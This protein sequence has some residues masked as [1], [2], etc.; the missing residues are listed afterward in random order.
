VQQA[1]RESIPVVALKADRDKLARALPASG[2]MESGK[3]FFLEGAQWWEGFKDELLRFTGKKDGQDD[4]VD[5]L[6]Y[7][8]AQLYRHSGDYG[9]WRNVVGGSRTRRR[10]GA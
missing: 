2:L 1:R 7:G 8:V 9:L 5:T 10:K 3:V 6:S 4:Q